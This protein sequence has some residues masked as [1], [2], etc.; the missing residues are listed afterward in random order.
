VQ[1]RTENTRVLNELG[2]RDEPQGDGNDP[3]SLSHQ[4]VVGRL[5]DGLYEVVEERICLLG[6]ATQEHLDAG[7]RTLVTIRQPMH[8]KERS[9][10]QMEDVQLG[11]LHDVEERHRNEEQ[12]KQDVKNP[13]QI[14]QEV[15]HIPYQ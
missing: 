9:T 10:H 8:E 11:K 7:E 6:V 4:P 3:D 5:I 12:H 14:C 15:L 13:N 1:E 2:Q